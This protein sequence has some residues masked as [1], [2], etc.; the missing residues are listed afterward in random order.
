[1]ISAVRTF[2]RRHVTF[3]VVVLAI[4]FPQGSHATAKPATTRSGADGVAAKSPRPAQARAPGVGTAGRA[5]A[6]LST[7]SGYGDAGYVHYFLLTAPDG[8]EEI[9]VGIAYPEQ[10]IAWSF[11]GMGVV[12]QPFLS[13]GVLDAG[14][15]EYAVRHLYGIRPFRD[16]DAMSELQAHLVRRV[17]LWVDGETGYCDPSS[18]AA[19]LSCLGFAMHVLF[20]GPGSAYPRLPDDFRRTSGPY[21]TTDDLLL[22]LAGLQQPTHD[23]RA[24]RIAGLQLPDVLRADLLRLSGLTAPRA[25]AQAGVGAAG[26]DAATVRRF[27]SADRGVQQK[28][29]PARRL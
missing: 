26:R 19:C 8:T 7:A 24:R 10:Q 21:Y 17:A 1:M 2:L 13:A 25:T 9:Q 23:A 18:G 11:P 29:T 20:P 27:R 22:Y 5:A 4:A 28:K 16:A 14:G 12:V 15:V 3:V 6:P